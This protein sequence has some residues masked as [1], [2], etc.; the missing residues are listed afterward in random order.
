MASKVVRGH[1]VPVFIF[2]A[3]ILVASLARLYKACVAHGVGRWLPTWMSRNAPTLALAA[4]GALSVAGGC[5]RLWLLAL[6]PAAAA[7]F[8]LRRLSDR[9]CI[10]GSVAVVS[11]T[12]AMVTLALLRMVPTSYALLPLPLL[13]VYSV[14]A[15]KHAERMPRIAGSARAVALLILLGIV[16]IVAYA[17]LEATPAPAVLSAVS[18]AAAAAVEVTAS[19]TGAALPSPAYP[20]QSTSTACRIVRAV[21]AP[22]AALVNCDRTLSSR[23]RQGKLLNGSFASLM[24]DSGA[25]LHSYSPFHSDFWAFTDISASY[26]GGAAGGSSVSPARGTI[27]CVGLD[28]SSPPRPYVYLIFDAAYAPTAVTRL[29]ASEPERLRGHH[30]CTQAECQLRADGA[31][32]PFDII[33]GHYWTDAVIIPPVDDPTLPPT[34]ACPPALRNV[35]WTVARHIAASGG[36]YID[37]SPAEKRGS[38]GSTARTLRSSRRSKRNRAQ[39]RGSR[40]EKRGSRTSAAPTPPPTIAP[41]STMLLSSAAPAIAPPSATAVVPTYHCT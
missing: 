29:F 7:S 34:S 25:G 5:S 35:D 22:L 13:A 33:S 30:V 38:Q 20:I 41:V 37:G 4:A 6:L 17:Y 3:L 31:R 1:P 19:V 12:A 9:G 39:K 21:A 32:L 15:Y 36:G 26:F 27:A 10:A 8:L 23:L 16:P 11:T 18:E 28:D 40:R 14:A 2:V 24:H